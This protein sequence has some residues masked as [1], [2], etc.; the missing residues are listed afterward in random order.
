MKGFGHRRF[1]ATDL[2]SE[3]T[4]PLGTMVQM[5]ADSA[6]RDLGKPGLGTVMSYSPRLWTAGTQSIVQRNAIIGFGCVSNPLQ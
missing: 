5:Q 3:R 1:T 4:F 6:F 2:P